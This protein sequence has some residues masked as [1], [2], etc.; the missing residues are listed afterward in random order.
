MS[1]PVTP[2]PFIIAMLRL[3][4]LPTKTVLIG[5]KH[6]TL[7]GGVLEYPLQLL[8][9][10]WGYMRRIYSKTQKYVNILVNS[11]KHPT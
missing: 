9:H 7:G 4:F 6:K 5:R 1:C 10:L 3:G 8:H 2:L 11:P